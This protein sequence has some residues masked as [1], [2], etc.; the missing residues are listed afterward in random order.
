MG[1]LNWGSN[2]Y[3]IRKHERELQAE[4]LAW[5]KRAAQQ[6]GTTWWTVA[7]AIPAKGNACIGA[8]D[9][10]NEYVFTRW[11][12]L[13]PGRLVGPHAADSWQAWWHHGPL[14]SVPQ[15]TRDSYEALHLGRH[16]AELTRAAKAVQTAIDEV[17]DLYPVSAKVLT[18]A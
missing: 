17:W 18:N 2:Q 6:F 12:K 3:Y 4:H 8:F 9:I 16:H 10:H 11:S 7:P 1:L 5:A 15:Q 13:K 14:T